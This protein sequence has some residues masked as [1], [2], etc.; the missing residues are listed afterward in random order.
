MNNIIFI[1]IGL[2]AG[3]VSGIFGI[4]GAVLVIP[5]LIFFCGFEQHM[6]Q[7]TS[8][9][10]MLPPIG[11]LAVIEYH[12]KGFVD[13]RA[14]VVICIAFLLGS[15]FGAKYAVDFSAPVLRKSFAGFLMVIAARMFFMK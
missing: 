14:A 11:I 12:N 13:F 15:Y 9:A 7:G 8:L 5:S 3:A 2:F 4:G 1:F 6:A 10:L